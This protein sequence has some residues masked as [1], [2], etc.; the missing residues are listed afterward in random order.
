MIRLKKYT[1]SKRVLRQFVAILAIVF[2]IVAAWVYWSNGT[3]PIWAWTLAL[4]L[5]VF[6]AIMP[7]RLVGFYSLWMNIG[8]GLGWVNTHLILALMFYVI[9]APLGIIFRIFGRGSLT[10]NTMSNVDTYA[11][12][13]L[14]RAPKHF[15]RIF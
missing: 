15:D 12:P 4:M 6:G 14:Q 1:A 2:A 3:L 9:I 13:T 8:H 5:L 7:N 11:V 10:L